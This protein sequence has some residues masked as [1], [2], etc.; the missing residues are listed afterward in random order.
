MAY[1][2]PEA[3]HTFAGP[4]FAYLSSGKWTIAD[5]GVP[6][7]ILCSLY[8]DSSHLLHSQGENRLAHGAVIAPTKILALLPP[9]CSSLPALNT[10][11]QDLLVSLSHGMKPRGDG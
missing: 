5:L 8:K 2:H 9:H 3:P 10:E 6:S 7:D 1:Y 11:W 4:Q